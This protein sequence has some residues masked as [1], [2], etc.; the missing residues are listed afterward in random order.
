MARAKSLILAEHLSSSSSNPFLSQFSIKSKILR[1]QPLKHIFREGIVHLLVPRATERCRPK[2]SFQNL[3]EA[4]ASR[5]KLINRQKSVSEMAVPDFIYRASDDQA[6]QA[7]K[8]C[9]RHR[10]IC[11]KPEQT[12]GVSRHLLQG[13]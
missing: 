10:T 11:R 4:F 2:S 8:I 5:E 9:Y 3:K 1:D 7:F 12:I 6:D 13:F